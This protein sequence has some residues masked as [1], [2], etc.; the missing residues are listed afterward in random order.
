[1]MYTPE[2]RAEVSSTLGL[3]IVISFLGIVTCGAMRNRWGAVDGVSGFTRG[4][5]RRHYKARR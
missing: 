4:Q 3:A 1:M 2:H 5:G